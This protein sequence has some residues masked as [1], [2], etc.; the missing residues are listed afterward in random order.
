M[1]EC[2]GLVWMV[3]PVLPTGDNEEM[4]VVGL[5]ATVACPRRMKSARNSAQ[6]RRS[7]KGRVRGGRGRGVGGDSNKGEEGLQMRLS[8][9]AGGGEGG[10]G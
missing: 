10:G 5:C 6:L 2:V 9:W 1:K 8:R 3:P 4:L 7:R